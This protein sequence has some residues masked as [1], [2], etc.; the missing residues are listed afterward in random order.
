MVINIRALSPEQSDILVL[1]RVFQRFMSE[2][3]GK[4]GKL[5]PLSQSYARSDLEVVKNVPNI[6]QIL[7]T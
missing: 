6:Q 4:S 7:L 3:M 5:H 1:N 2:G